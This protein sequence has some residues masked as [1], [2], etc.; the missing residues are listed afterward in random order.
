M[1]T[2]IPAFLAQLDANEHTPC[3]GQ[4]SLFLSAAQQSVRRAK[5]LCAACPVREAC[6]EHAIRTGESRG[7][8][9]GLTPEER[10]VDAVPAC[11]TRT[12]RLRHLRRRESCQTCAE[13]HAE[14]VRRSRLERLEAEHAQ[15]AGGSMAGYRLER[16]LGIPTCDACRA[17]RLVYEAGRPR[18]RRRQTWSGEAD[19]LRLRGTL[20][21]LSKVA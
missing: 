20:R 18:S 16:L 4:S 11:G 7:V 5:A 12:A 15:P 3:F 6:A 2:I 19:Y 8:W 1:N 9:G 10:G 14:E 21:N 17:A 13:A